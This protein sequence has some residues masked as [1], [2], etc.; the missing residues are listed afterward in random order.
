MEA[1]Q[2]EREKDKIKKRSEIREKIKFVIDY[3]NETAIK[4]KEIAAD[5]DFYNKD[6]DCGQE[7]DLIA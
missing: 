7:I 5:Y 1:A 4:P 3:E 6:L 2:K